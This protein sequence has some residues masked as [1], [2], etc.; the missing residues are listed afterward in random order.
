MCLTNL[1][2][3]MHRQKGEE[4]REEVERVKPTIPPVILTD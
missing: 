4:L 1:Q 2:H 3:H